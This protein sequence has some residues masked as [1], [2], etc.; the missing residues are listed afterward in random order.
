[1]VPRRGAAVGC[2]CGV[3]RAMVTVMAE[4]ARIGIVA[5]E[6]V[7][8]WQHDALEALRAG[9]TTIAARFAPHGDGTPLP[10]PGPVARTAGGAAAAFAP[11]SWA[12]PPLAPAARA[13]ELDAV[14]ALVEPAAADV[15]ALGSARWGLWEIVL[16]GEPPA[17]AAVERGAA[18]E[19]RVERRGPL[20]TVLAQGAVAVD[21]A[22]YGRT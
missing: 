19:V 18:A 7:P 13:G 9:G 11:R 20:R 15:A 2:P 10:L 14:L 12:A 6:T 16:P 3:P 4:T 17:F 22:S 8:R 1:M 5:G 21:A